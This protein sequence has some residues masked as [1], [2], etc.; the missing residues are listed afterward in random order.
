MSAAVRT[1]TMLILATGRLVTAV[2]V[3]YFLV[4]KTAY[5]RQ[6]LI[7]SL[8]AQRAYLASGVS[9]VFRALRILTFRTLLSYF[10]ACIFSSPFSTFT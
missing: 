6:A 8:G 3:L 7:T 1:S 4:V 5:V 10:T 9:T 2:H